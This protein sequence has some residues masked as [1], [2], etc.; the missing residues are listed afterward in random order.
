MRFD[1]E[2]GKMATDIPGFGRVAFN[3]VGEG[4][5]TAE[6]VLHAATLTATAKLVLQEGR[7]SS[8]LKAALGR[9]QT[10]V[11][12]ALYGYN[13]DTKMHIGRLH[14]INDVPVDGTAREGWAAMVCAHEGH[15][16]KAPRLFFV[17]E[18][19]KQPEDLVCDMIS[20]K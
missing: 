4:V 17:R 11:S 14:A 18:S 19:T 12:V 9:L 13:P 10:D 15:N 1:S 3:T 5:K 2:G 7:G 8:H 20:K 6:G 16:H